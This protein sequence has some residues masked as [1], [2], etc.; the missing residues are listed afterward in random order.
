MD[1]LN[2]TTPY[3]DLH[4]QAAARIYNIPENQVTEA[5]R[6]VGK[7]SNHHQ[8]YNTGPVTLAKVINMSQKTVGNNNERKT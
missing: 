1:V 3:E 4:A 6:R 5:Q 2:N 7:L 8:L